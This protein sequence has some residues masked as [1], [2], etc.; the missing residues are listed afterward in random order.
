MAE[1]LLTSDEIQYVL[2]VVNASPWL[3][4]PDIISFG[5]NKTD[6][7]KVTP[8]NGVIIIQGDKD[9][10][11]EHVHSRH[12]FWS[13]NSYWKEVN[14][15]IRLDN[16]SLFSR[17]STP[18]LDYSNIA[19]EL[20]LESNKNDAKNKF[21]ESVDLYSGK[22]NDQTNGDQVYHLITYKGTP[23]LHSLFPESRQNNRHNSS[24]KILPFRKGKMEG[25]VLY[26]PTVISMGI[27]YH[28][29]YDKI[30][31][32]FEIYRLMD[33]RREVGVIRDMGLEGHIELYNVELPSDCCLNEA[34][35]S[36]EMENI[37]YSDLTPIEKRIKNYHEWKTK[38]LK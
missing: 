28:D 19:D 2:S 37:Y 12:D 4:H 38:K 36:I 9:T 24:N 33:E 11:F 30:V 15:E 25:Q 18:I 14:N 32:S 1:T 13:T 17:K 21:P 3:R 16:P 8:I 7:L 26:N 10:G 6:I 31:Y 5:K 29:S 27:P 20:F 35:L 22:I 23:I 34:N